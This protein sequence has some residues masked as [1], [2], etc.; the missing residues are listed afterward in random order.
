MLAPGEKFDRY[1]IVRLLG[2]GGMA[3]VFEAESPLGINVVLKV[4]NLELASDPEVRERFRREGQIQYTLRHPHIA[5]VTDIVE[6]NGVPAL[7]VDL[8][9]GRDLAAEIEGGRTFSLEEV[10]K[11]G[12]KLLDALRVAHEHGF[13]HRD[14]KPGNIFLEKKDYGFE[15]VLMDFGIAKI[16]EAAALTRAREFAGTPAY[17][18]PEQ[19]E[20]TRDVDPRSDVY[21][22]G[23]VMWELLAGQE[24][25]AKAGDDPIAILVAVI[26]EPIGPLPP[27]VPK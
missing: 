17:A 4:L 21:S 27:S 12:I 19:I 16:E 14:I 6:D 13:I 22:F 3:T 8:M 20:S 25:Y 10:L 7:V 1:R 23:V 11:I 24:P 18:S 2:E 15:P 5:R 9:R 26:R